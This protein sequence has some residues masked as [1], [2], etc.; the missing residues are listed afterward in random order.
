MVGFERCKLEVRRLCCS[1]RTLI[2]L[3]LLVLLAPL[4]ALFLVFMRAHLLAFLLST[5][6]LASRT[7]R[8]APD[9]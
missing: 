4:L 8:S 7:C 6:W 3:L 5:L 1:R 2:I 9:W